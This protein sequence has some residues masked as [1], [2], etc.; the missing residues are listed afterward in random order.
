MWQLI[1]VAPNSE[2]R[3]SR[4]LD[5]GI[6]VDV[7]AFRVRRRLVLRGKVVIRRVPAF[8]GYVFVSAGTS[9]EEVR[10]VLGVFDFVRIGEAIAEITDSIVDALLDLAVEDG[11]LPIGEELESARFKNGDRVLI[12]NLNFD[13]SGVFRSLE[14]DSRAIVEVEWF[15]R[16]VPVS[17][18]EG[19]L[20]LDKIE[21]RREYPR[22]IRRRRR[23]LGK[24]ERRL[25]YD[26]PS[27][28]TVNI[29]TAALSP[30]G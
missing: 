27:G 12:R 13:T 9:F 30:S 24:R 26:R 29:P 18:P 16:C 1:V 19:D 7:L 15:G 6:G 28:N 8:P 20:T 22:P 21:N 5:E 10:S 4:V 14:S 11:T 3:V 25:L 17:V 2:T 23:R